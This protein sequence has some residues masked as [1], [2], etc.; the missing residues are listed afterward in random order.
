MSTILLFR[1]EARE[2]QKLRQL[3]RNKRMGTVSGDG[4]C[5]EAN[6][7]SLPP[8]FHPAADGGARRAAIPIPVYCRPVTDDP[9]IQV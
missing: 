5:V 9:S 7:W 3:E 2:A 6:G 1:S 8:K 4:G